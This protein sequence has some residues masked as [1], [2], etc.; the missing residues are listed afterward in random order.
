M[1]EEASQSYEEI[2]E[3]L[4]NALS[5]LESGNLSL[6]DALTVYE[7]GVRLSEQAQELLSAA[8]L[9]I[10]QLRADS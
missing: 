8:E 5:L 3:A 4:D 6:N 9:R 1:P 10:E 2:V 7:T